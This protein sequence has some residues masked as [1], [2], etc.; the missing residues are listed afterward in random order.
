MVLI[1]H[2]LLSWGMGFLSW[3]LNQQYDLPAIGILGIHPMEESLRKM[4]FKLLS[5]DE[6]PP[7]QPVYPL[8]N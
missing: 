3:G 2:I 5:L 4:A 6:H 7:I 8:V 1:L